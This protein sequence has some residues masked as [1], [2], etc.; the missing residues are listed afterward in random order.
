MQRG[1]GVARFFSS[2]ND[3]EKSSLTY[4]TRKTKDKRIILN[5]LYNKDKYHHFKR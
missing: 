4:V 2:H 1:A 5:Q 3:M